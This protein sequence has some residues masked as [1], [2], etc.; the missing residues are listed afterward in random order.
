MICTAHEDLWN[1]RILHRDI[2][3]HN[4][5]LSPPKTEGERRRGLLIDFDYAFFYPPDKTDGDAG[6]DE[7]AGGDGEIAGDDG[8]VVSG[9][10]EVTGGDGGAAD[11]DKTTSQPPGGALL[12]HTV[13]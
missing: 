4:V 11:N 13:L 6:D 1:G 3:L 5:M 12:H 7:V 9:D 8:E 2:S 10:G